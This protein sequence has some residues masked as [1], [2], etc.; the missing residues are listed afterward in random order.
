VNETRKTFASVRAIVIIGSVSLVLPYLIAW[1]LPLLTTAAFGVYDRSTFWR[2]FPFRFV[3]SFEVGEEYRLLSV[4]YF[5]DVLF[6]VVLLF[7]ARRWLCVRKPPFI[8]SNDNTRN[9]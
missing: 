1:Y 9:A 2:G 5:G 8:T 4:A 6:W 3:H 7:V